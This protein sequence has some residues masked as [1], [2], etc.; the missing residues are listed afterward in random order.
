MANTLP[1]TDQPVDAFDPVSKP[2]VHYPMTTT[3]ATKGTGNGRNRPGAPRNNYNRMRHGLHA[4]KLPA[5]C[6]YIEN[7]RNKLRRQVETE[8]VAARGKTTVYDA[9]LIQSLCRHE[10]RAQL[11]QRWLR[12]SETDGKPLPI[13]DRAQLL[14]EISSATDARDRCLEK[15]N[16][17]S[18]A[19]DPFANLYDATPKPASESNHHTAQRH[20]SRT[21]GTEADTEVVSPAQRDPGDS[22]ASHEGSE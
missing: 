11:L 8:I 22:T 14:R 19:G 5:D 21:N 1:E 4:G 20:T 3:P 6:K 18:D 12:E 17:P 7:S 13:P 10:T 2:D 15:L 16:L 9:A